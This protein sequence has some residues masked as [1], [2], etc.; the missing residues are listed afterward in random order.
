MQILIRANNNLETAISTVESVTEYTTFDLVLLL[1]SV[2]A[3]AVLYSWISPANTRFAERTLQRNADFDE[4][5]LYAYSAKI[6]PVMTAGLLSQQTSGM[7]LCSFRIASVF[8]PIIRI[9]VDKSILPEQT[10]MPTTIQ[11]ELQA[12]I[13]ALNLGIATQPEAEAGVIN[14]KY[15][16]P[17]R[18]K[19]AILA[20]APDPDLTE[21]NNHIAD[22]TIHFTQSEIEITASQISDLPDLSTIN[23]HIANT[24]NPHSVTVEQI[25]AEPAN[26]NIQSHI[27]NTSNPHSVTPTQ[28]GVYTTAEVDTAISNAIA[29]LV[30]TA[31]ATLDTLNE[32][33]A[34]LGDDE[35][36]ATTVTDALA[37]KSDIGHTHDDR[38]YTETEVDALIGDTQRL[39]LYPNTKNISGSTI[40]KGAVVQFAGSQGDFLLIK[41]AVPAE[42]AT[43]PEA[44]MGLAQDDII[45]NSFGNVVWFGQVTNMR[46][47]PDNLDNGD[48]LYFDTTTGGLTNV[49]PSENKIIVAAVE[50][51]SSNS[52]AT[53]GILLVRPKWVSRDINQIDG[54]QDELDTINDTLGDIDTI[55]A[56]VLGV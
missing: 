49:A 56:S 30:D 10:E 52:N 38:Y 9:P 31:P 47:N 36:F 44:L 43:N 20:L 28:L 45:D 11:E 32:L 24:N 48:I 42:I 23:A 4:E 26:A 37:G 33:A 50:K 27:S 51:V 34:A 1:P 22:D 40:L 46:V 2:Q 41:N 14:N 17:L 16:T 39:Q 53:N 55:L 15:M 7:A 21:I 35:N 3:S 25:G 54:L 19:Q 18:T 13:D 5:G 8:S 29:G 12:Q 6:Y